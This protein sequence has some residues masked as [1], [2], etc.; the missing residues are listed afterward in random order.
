MVMSIH[1]TELLLKFTTATAIR[2]LNYHKAG[3]REGGG[4]GGEG[5]FFGLVF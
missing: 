4:G 3:G 5:G 2:I 1:N